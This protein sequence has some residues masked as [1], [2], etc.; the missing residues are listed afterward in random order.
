M[1]DIRET[2]QERDLPVEEKAVGRQPL[3]PPLGTGAEGGSFEFL[4]VQIEIARLRNLTVRNPSPSQRGDR[5]EKEAG[6]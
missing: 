3:T 1:G 4:A 5:Q 2:A 6:G